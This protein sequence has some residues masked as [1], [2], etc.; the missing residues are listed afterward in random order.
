MGSPPSEQGRDDD[1]GPQ[2]RV[3]IAAPFAV[4]VYEVTRREYERYVTA[5]G[6]ATGVVCRIMADD[7]FRRVS[8]VSWR[9]PG[10]LQSDT[11]PVVC[12]N[13]EEAQAYVRWLSRRTGQEYCLLSE[14]EWEYVARGGADTAGHWEDGQ[15]DQCR[16]A[17]GADAAA[18]RRH[19]GWTAAGC[20]DRHYRTAPA[21]SFLPNR[22]GVHDVLGN[23]R[24]WTADC[25]ECRLR[26][27]G[28]RR[29]HVGAGRLRLS[30]GTMR[31]LA[32]CAGGPALGRPQL[33]A[34]RTPQRPTR[35]P[36]GPHAVGAPSRTYL[37][38]T[39]VETAPPAR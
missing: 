5:T 6:R 12:V 30:G 33:G 25:G 8:G 36:C 17:N 14:A 16:Y 37:P 2:R 28:R 13:W 26:G 7:R 35:I 38:R 29:Q 10:F 19:R 1:E 20:D 39:R 15:A 21:G 4:G 3:A 11:E 22:Y 9:A 23:V 32:Q 34:A 18:K 27:S 31:R 24:E